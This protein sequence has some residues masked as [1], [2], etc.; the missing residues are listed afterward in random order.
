MSALTSSVCLRGSRKP[1]SIS[2]Q[3]AVEM[4]RLP[5]AARATVYSSH[6]HDLSSVG[7]AAAA[8]PGGG[9]TIALTNRQR[10][11]GHIPCLQRSLVCHRHA[12]T[13]TSTATRGNPP[14]K[15]WNSKRA[16]LDRP[17]R[18]RNEVPCRGVTMTDPRCP[19]RAS[20]RDSPRHDGLPPP[21]QHHHQQRP[22]PG[23][24]RLF[25]LSAHAPPPSPSPAPILFLSR[26]TPAHV[27]GLGPASL[28]RS[29]FGIFSG[30]RR[31]VW[32]LAGLLAALNGTSSPLSCA[33]YLS[34]FVS[35]SLSHLL[36]PCDVWAC[37]A[38]LWSP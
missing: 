4:A 17:T 8:I 16:G 36:F 27:H 25:R 15:I 7:K 32:F 18:I 12:L 6:L 30:A 19:L 35:L 33:A 9:E 5:Y 11:R 20:A 34:L 22:S 38:A 37:A 2:N 21:Y 24:H 3:C 29:R 1:A 14:A 13:I 10:L 23:L 31:G 28:S 26:L